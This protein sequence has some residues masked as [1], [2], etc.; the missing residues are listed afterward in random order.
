MLVATLLA[1]LGFLVTAVVTRRYGLRLGGTIVLGVMPVYT[2]KS[3]STLPIFLVSAVLAYVTLGYVKEHTLIYGRDEFVVA[4][5]AGSLLPALVYLIAVLLPGNVRIELSQSVFVGS[6]L[7]GIAAF[8]VHQV[9]PGFRRRDVGVAAGCYLGLLL[10]GAALVGPST[11]FLAGYTPLVLFAHTADIAVLRGAVVQGFVDP[12]FVGRPF[13]IGVYVLTLGLSEYVRTAFGVRIGTVGLGLIA[14]YTVSSWRLLALFLV[15]LSAVF[16][17]DELVH[18]TTFLYGR[19]LL[20]VGTA[21][22]VVLSVPATVVLGVTN[23][24]SLLFTAIIAGVVAY[25]VHYTPP[26][27]RRLQAALGTATFV[28]LLVLVRG[29]IDAGPEGFPTSFGF[30]AAALG[31]GVVV[32]GYI[33]ARGMRIEQPG[34]AAVHASSVFT[35][36]EE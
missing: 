21:V 1:A 4:I 15:L 28:L 22:A 17:L 3:F 34:R 14:V 33:A 23:G 32:V 12:P 26:R 27:E 6:L 35:R 29:V 7:S 25:Y 8:N 2:L 36:G 31:L 18:R 16:L 13:V 10:L 5:L 20:S 9:R 11:R 24:L 30:P 19:A